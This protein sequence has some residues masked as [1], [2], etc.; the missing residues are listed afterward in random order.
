MAKKRAEEVNYL[1]IIITIIVVIF[2]FQS[3]S[4]SSTAV[5]AQTPDA[6]A[7]QEYIDAGKRTEINDLE[8]VIDY[9]NDK[10]KDLYRRKDILKGKMNPRHATIDQRLS[11]ESERNAAKAKRADQLIKAG[12]LRE[13]NKEIAARKAKLVEARANLSHPSLRNALIALRKDWKVRAMKI[14]QELAKLK[15]VRK[16]TA[17]TAY[18]ESAKKGNVYVT[19]GSSADTL[20]WEWTDDTYK[21]VYDNLKNIDKKAAR[22]NENKI[23][24]LEI[25]LQ[26]V[27]TKVTTSLTPGELARLSQM[28]KKA[29]WW[30][31]IRGI[32]KRNMKILLKAGLSP[33]LLMAIGL[34]QPA[35]PI[36]PVM[37]GGSMPNPEDY[38]GS[39][40]N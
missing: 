25:N 40:P 24:A 27:K 14:K 38:G 6:L 11:A 7:Y 33:S 39:F 4:Q 22:L 20:V 34:M 29:T 8:K 16:I 9:N 23:K 2:L 28:A 12:E 21:G 31:R 18:L 15:N 13:V 10:L 35:I 36:S 19:R 5:E 17:S 30:D 32:K 1:V 37:P 3:Q 26:N